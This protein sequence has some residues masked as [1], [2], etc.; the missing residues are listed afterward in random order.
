MHKNKAVLEA[1][2]QA[3]ESIAKS[4]ADKEQLVLQKN[5]LEGEV[6]QIQQKKKE[7]DGKI[8]LLMDYA[9]KLDIKK[10]DLKALHSRQ[11]R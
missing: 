5:R 4:E 7:L 3:K 6:G 8:T 9:D 11:V 10:E 2:R 1:E